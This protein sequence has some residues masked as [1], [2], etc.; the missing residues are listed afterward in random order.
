MVHHGNI[1]SFQLLLWKTTLSDIHAIIWMESAS[2]HKSFIHAGHE[3]THFL[4]L[5]RT[6]QWDDGMLF[7]HIPPLSIPF[8]N[9][10]GCTL[11]QF[12]SPVLYMYI[13]F[14]WNWKVIVTFWP[15]EF[16][17]CLIHYFIKQNQLF[18]WLVLNSENFPS[19]KFCSCTMYMHAFTTPS[20]NSSP[21][22]YVF[23]VVCVCTWIWWISIITSNCGSPQL[24]TLSNC[25]F[26]SKVAVF[27]NIYILISTADL[28]WFVN[29][30]V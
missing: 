17:M 20:T 13:L 8:G 3:L 18:T 7:P 27:H 6:H 9:D 2:K 29:S 10:K 11:I 1:I 4:S 26:L 22:I 16:L 28:T 5:W 23:F 14:K 15:S 25:K 30:K 21:S 12:S 24:F 19:H